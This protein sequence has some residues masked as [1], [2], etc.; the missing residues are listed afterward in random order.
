MNEQPRIDI[1]YRNIGRITAPVIVG[2]LSHTAMGVVDTLM[3]GQL[4]VT[5][6]AAVGLGTYVSWWPMTFVLG[7]MAGVNTLVAQAE[8]A[9]RH[10]SA[11][12]AFWQGVYLALFMAGGLAAG[13]LAVPWIF[14]W[15]GPEP[16]VAEIAV[17]YMRI[18]MLGGL[19]FALF[20]VAENFFRG[21]GR[22][23]ILMWCALAQLVLNSS[24][25]YLLI[26]GKMGLPRLGPEGAA[27]GTVMAQLVVA[28]FLVTRIL[29]PEELRRRYGFFEVWRPD[30]RILRLLVG[31]SLPIAVQFFMEMG[32]V[33]V[34]CAVIA[35]LGEAE[36]AATNVV[37]QVWSVAFM[38]A[39]AL[40]VGA[41]TLVGQCIGAGEPAQ[42]RRVVKR[43]LLIGYGLAAVMGT[44]YLT[45][46][47]RL[48]A[49]FVNSGELERLLPFARPL[50]IVVVVC[51]VLDVVF[52]ILTGAL[53]GAGDTKYPMWVVIGS[54]W[55]LW[56]PLVFFV[57]P[58][59]G[60]VG[61]W[62]CVIVHA[63]VVPLLLLWRF[64][65]ESW[66]RPPLEQSDASEIGVGQALPADS[67]TAQAV[68]AGGA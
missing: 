63:T 61:A 28:V 27:W 48:M 55:L 14:A 12:V 59:F 47:E 44:L 64:R 3:V 21:V 18:R 50:F 32:G 16:E 35:R 40:G 62:S 31:L 9:K 41:T 38:S 13:W 4:G 49:L 10:R 68:P 20:A 29:G 1:S 26:F 54:T 17:D 51:M 56:V 11:G 23:T 58:H 15:I 25:N 52:H 60:L 67:V 8:G 37:I 24:L 43:V 39:V 66:L 19:G 22:T 2:Q 36:M 46:P 30:G 57:T 7:M 42:A 65:G 34:F 5:A 6:L 33:T 45:M 53:R